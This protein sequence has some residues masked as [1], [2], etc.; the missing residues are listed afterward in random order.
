MPKGRKLQEILHDNDEHAL[1]GE[2]DF[3]EIP[4]YVT[5]TMNDSI[6]V[7]KTPTFVEGFLSYKNFL[8]GE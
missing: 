2:N 7:I 5:D 6:S 4:T 8:S 3:S 1:D